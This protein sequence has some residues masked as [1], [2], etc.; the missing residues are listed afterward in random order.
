MV[1]GQ[2]KNDE[3]DADIEENLA[4]GCRQVYVGTLYDDV[5]VPWQRV[6]AGAVAPR[7]RDGLQLQCDQSARAEEAG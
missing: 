6:A 2:R 7:G 3:Y 5:A 4:W 1:E